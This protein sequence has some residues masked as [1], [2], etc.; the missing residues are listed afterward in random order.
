MD[1]TCSFCKGTGL[2]QV[3]L[4][5]KCSLCGDREDNLCAEC[6]N[7]K[8]GVLWKEC[9][10]CVGSGKNDESWKLSLE[11]SPKTTNI[12][13]INDFHIPALP[14]TWIRDGDIMSQNLDDGVIN[15]LQEKLNIHI[16]S[17]KAIIHMMDLWIGGAETIQTAEMEGIYSI[18]ETIQ[19]YISDKTYIIPPKS[20]IIF[21]HGMNYEAVST[22]N[23]PT[24]ISFTGL[25]K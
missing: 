14:N 5:L 6:E 25:T 2:E 11:S 1:N 18:D 9:E 24:I 10:K 16:T 7:I 17:S 4:T 8:K 13:L 15:K 3:D 23:I 22:S 21:Q 19:V 20:L 12:K